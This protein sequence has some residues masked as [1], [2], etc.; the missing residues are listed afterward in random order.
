M[1]GSPGWAVW[2]FR[3]SGRASRGLVFCVEQ[4]GELGGQDGVAGVRVEGVAQDCLGLRVVFLLEEQPGER[5]GG[6]GIMGPGGEEFAQGL[7]G[8]RG[9]VAGA[10]GEF[11]GEEGVFGSFGRELEGGEEAVACCLG[12]AGFVEAGEGAEGSGFEESVSVRDV[13]CG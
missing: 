11:G 1:L 8:V 4:G 7:F 5:G 3:T 13:G 9:S 6:L 12:M 2:S 10:G